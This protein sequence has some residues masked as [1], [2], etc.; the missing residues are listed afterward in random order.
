MLNMLTIVKPSCLIVKYIY[1]IYIYNIYTIYIHISNIIKP[2]L[3]DFFLF[4]IHPPWAGS[5]QGIG[6]LLQLVKSFT[7]PELWARSVKMRRYNEQRRQEEA[8]G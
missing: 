4:P 6:H 1:I 3:L 7:L 5:P 8:V 2:L